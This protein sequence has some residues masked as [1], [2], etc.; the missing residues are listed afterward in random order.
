MLTKLIPKIKEPRTMRRQAND[1]DTHFKRL[2]DLVESKVSFIRI[3]PACEREKQ[4]IDYNS[5]FL[6][7]ERACF[8]IEAKWLKWTGKL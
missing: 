6:Q 4:D 5:N 8:I 2:W 7:S 1:T 3:I